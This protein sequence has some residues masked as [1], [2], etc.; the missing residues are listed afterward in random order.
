MGIHI[1]SKEKRIREQVRVY[2]VILIILIIVNNNTTVSKVDINIY[3]PKIGGDSYTIV[4]ISDFHSMDYSLSGHELY[5]TIREINPDSVVI[6]GDLLNC[7]AKGSSLMDDMESIKKQ[8]KKIASGYHTYYI[9]GNHEALLSNGM[10]KKLIQMLEKIGIK[11][12]NGKVIKEC[13]GGT[14][15]RLVGIPDPAMDN[16]DKQD[17]TEYITN[18]I[19]SSK[20]KFNSKNPYTILLAHRPERI[21]EYSKVELP[22]KS[23]TYSYYNIDLVLSGHTHGGLITLPWLNGLIAPDQGLFPE[24]NS[25]LYRVCNTDLIVSSGLGTSIE[26][27]R[28]F[29][30]PEINIIK[31]SNPDKESLMESIKYIIGDIV[32][33]MKH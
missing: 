1:I 22:S 23:Y 3:S 29:N 24:Y 28:W 33:N 14:E 10:Y 15:V 11:D 8:F 25:G 26:G 17:E 20:T 6:T 31:L 16:R 18:I 13:K 4:Q 21:R 2:V 27:I 12:I 7:K 30:K 19:Q 32:S 9:S 5:D